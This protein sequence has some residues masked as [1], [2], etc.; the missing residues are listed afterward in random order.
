MPG[1]GECLSERAE[2]GDDAIGAVDHQVSVSGQRGDLGRT[3][4][5]GETWYTCGAE[6]ADGTERRH[7]TQIVSAEENRA[8]SPFR[9][10]V[11]KG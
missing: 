11:C 3:A 10:E 8:R 2:Q 1:R 4:A 7:I 5:H 9:C 6:G